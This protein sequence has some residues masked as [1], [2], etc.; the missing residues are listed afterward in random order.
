M[1]CL[2]W[3]EK[4]CTKLKAK[5]GGLPIHKDDAIADSIG[6]SSAQG[7]PRLF[8]VPETYRSP[9]EKQNLRQE[10]QL[11]PSIS[12][13]NLIESSFEYEERKREMTQVLRRE[14]NRKK[15]PKRKLFRFL[16]LPD[17]GFAI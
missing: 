10:R 3:L 16:N 6:A 7:C 5:L 13:R 9:T 4:F 14:G 17:G 15:N 8:S 2:S 1:K 11:P 12:V